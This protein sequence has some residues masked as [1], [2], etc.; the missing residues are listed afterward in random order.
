MSRTKLRIYTIEDG[1]LAD[2]LAAWT[3]GVVP[4]RRQFG[5]TIDAW[6]VPDQ[7]TVI[8][9]I[10]YE[11]EGTFEAAEQAYY[12]SPERRGLDPDPGSFVVAKDDRWLEPIDLPG[13][14]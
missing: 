7:Q 14:G 9:T 3:A 12:D 8:W 2:F 4:L 6:T 1:R 10:T 11:G 5:F 13:D